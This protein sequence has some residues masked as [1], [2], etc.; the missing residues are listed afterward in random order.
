[1]NGVPQHRVSRRK[2]RRSGYFPQ[3][4]GGD[5]PLRETVCRLGHALLALLLVLGGSASGV[6]LVR[7]GKPATVIVARPDTAPFAEPSSR[8]S[9]SAT[10]TDAP[11]RPRVRAA[12]DP[13]SD[14]MLAARTLVDWVKKMTGAELPITNTV[15]PEGAGVFIGQAAM[16]AGLKLHDI[17]SPS[18]EGARIEADGR[19]ILVAGQSEAGTLK[20]VCRFLEE[21]GCRYF[22][23]GPLGEVYP[24]RRTLSVGRLAITERPGLLNR[25]IKGPSWRATLWKAWNGAGGLPLQHQHAWGQY[26]SAALYSEYPDFFAMGADGRRKPGQWLCTSNP[27][28][29]RYFALQVIA[30]IQ[31][32]TPNPSISPPDGRGYCQ[33][34]ACKAQDDVTQIEPST[35]A[36]S[37]SRRY[38]DF[39]DDVARQVAKECPDSVL[40]SYCYADYSQPPARAERLS[41]NLCA[42][43]APIRYC[44]L[45]EIGHPGCASRKQ[46]VGMVD[47]WANLAGRLG[48]YNYLYNLADA[49]LPSFKFTPCK[50]EFPYLAGKGLSAMTIEVLSN[51]HIYGPQIYLS[52]RLAYDPKADAEEI[53][54]DYWEK[55]YGPNAAAH[56]KRY[57]MGVAAA[58]ERLQSHAGSFFGLQQVFTPG[59]LKECEMT[60]QRAAEAA[61]GDHNYSER[62][63]LHAEGFRSAVEY[64]QLCQEMNR[65]DFAAAQAI[66]DRM[67]ARLRGLADKG[68]A[69]REYATAYLERFLGKNVRAGAAATAAPGQVLQVL[70]DPWKF[71]LDEA[72]RGREAGW[73]KPQFD[74][75]KWA[76]VRT[77]DITLDAQGF[78]KNTV[79]WYRTRF[80]VAEQCARLQLF[81]TEVD[82]DP[83]VH[84]NGVKVEPAAALL[85][86]TSQSAT[87]TDNR[88]KPR[89][90]FTV[91]IT[92]AVRP[93]ENVLSVRVDHARIT[94]LSLGGILRPVV[95]IQFPESKSG[96][97]N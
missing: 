61:R 76:V 42:V 60:L 21:L 58:T 80:N 16:D 97:A 95:L 39:F 81:F 45:H 30:A 96:H 14:E 36:V 50:K 11:D 72:N 54:E 33:C 49:T 19:R 67:L 91:N 47:G 94:E 75:S 79:L 10:K 22:M 40:S 41:S 88:L 63:A 65:G 3:K 69:N 52:L 18:R 83:E 6:D 66:L 34:A 85:P 68:W 4:A 7:D 8:K 29:R 15:P 27:E 64:R 13:Q 24:R 89:M 77:R 57:W 1:M 12:S 74:D 73:H 53:M 37:V 38:V 9:R 2:P 48:Y 56:M 93:G 59:F 71:A 44:R 20:A 82:G 62:V 43:L 35:G 92:N 70:P 31:S 90:P 87:D 46:Q 17:V 32:G 84:V 55:F 26:V 23:D 28:L 5:L 86:A 78:D 51:W 25:N